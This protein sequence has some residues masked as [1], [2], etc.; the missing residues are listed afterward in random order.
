MIESVLQSLRAA[1]EQASW[2]SFPLVFAGGALV[3]LNPCV[4]GVYPAM[5]AF[6]SAQREQHRRRLF[7]MVGLFVLG[8]AL[9]YAAVGVLLSV[10][11]QTAGVSPTTWFYIGGAVCVLVGLHWADILPWKFRATIPAQSRWANLT[12]YAGAFA[13]GALFALIASPC[14]TPVLVLI[15]PLVTAAGSPA[16]G[17]ALLFTYA[18][19]HSLPVVLL[20]TATVAFTSLQRIADHAETIRKVGGWLLIAVGLYLLWAA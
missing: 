4:Y 17:G 6:V 13:L 16:Y 3:S 5:V 1:L 20:G 14:T 8:L 19:G 12:G 18:L 15:V 9:V 2:A 10:V 7:V 11:G